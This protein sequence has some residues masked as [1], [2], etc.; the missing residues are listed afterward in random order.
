MWGKGSALKMKEIDEFILKS[1]DL[2]RNDSNKGRYFHTLNRRDNSPTVVHKKT[3]Q[4]SYVIKGSGIV[5]LNGKECKINE[6]DK[7]VITA[8]T[9]H[10]FKANDEEMILFRIHI[11]DSGRENDREIVEGKDYNRYV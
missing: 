10:R 7:V 11:P 9:H 4:F 3:N 2:L 5:W 1:Y 6:G 8:G